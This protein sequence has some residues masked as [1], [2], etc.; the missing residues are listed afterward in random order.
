MAMHTKG[1]YDVLFDGAPYATRRQGRSIKKIRSNPSYFSTEKS[2]PVRTNR[3]KSKK[4]GLTKAA[5]NRLAASAFVFPRTRRYPINDLYHGKLALQYAQWTKTSRKDLPKVK[6]AVFKKYPSLIKWWNENHP[7]D[8]WTKGKGR[9][10]RAGRGRGRR[11]IAANPSNFDFSGYS[12]EQLRSRIGQVY[13]Q[14]RFADPMQQE[15]MA[16]WM[17]AAKAHLAGIEHGVGGLGSTP[18]GGPVPSWWGSDDDSDLVLSDGEEEAYW[19]P[20]QSLP[21]GVSRIYHDEPE[22]E[23]EP[24]ETAAAR[25][26][27]DEWRDKDYEEKGFRPEWRDPSTQWENNPRSNPSR[28]RQSLRTKYRK[29]HGDNWWKKKAI[30][31]RFRK[32]LKR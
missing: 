29:K 4:K 28:R 13:S 24:R 7:E 18:T 26:D 19:P 31:A 27:D 10:R 6:A 9:S 11:R 5:R 25:R 8:K 16:Y 32:E 1:T 20:D 30:Y 23:W 2:M 21:V 12:P 22:E 3:R 14:S 15:E 17:Q